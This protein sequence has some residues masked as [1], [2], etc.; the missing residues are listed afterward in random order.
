M[1]YGY[2]VN[3]GKGEVGFCQALQEDRDEDIDMAAA[4]KLG[5]DTAVFCM[6][7]DL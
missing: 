1:G 7:I 2:E 5:D 6:E 4:G 3:S